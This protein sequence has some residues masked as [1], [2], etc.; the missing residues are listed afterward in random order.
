MFRRKADAFVF[1]TP[2]YV[3][4]R[5]FIIELGIKSV[6]DIG[7]GNPQ[8]LK[9]YIYPFADDIVGIDLQEVVDQIDETFGHWYGFD[10]NEDSDSIRFDKVFGLIIAADVVEHL[11][12]PEKMLELI[13][14][15]ADEDTIIFISTPEKVLNRPFE[16]TSH[17]QEYSKD[18]MIKM[19]AD[20]G[21]RIESLKIYME[22][23]TANPYR[24]NM[25]L[26][27]K[28]KQ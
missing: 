23:N 28:E 18:E 2:V 20:G 10:L 17:E 4:A 1:Q 5:N 25:F 15:H 16:N 22:R 24:N 6:L 14:A 21:L 7:C 27:K 11:R 8:K 9:A 19:L 12:R 13:R 3:N 26:C